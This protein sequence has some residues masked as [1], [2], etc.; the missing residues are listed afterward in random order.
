MKHRWMMAALAALLLCSCSLFKSEVKTEPADDLAVSGMEEFDKKNYKE[1]LAKF[2]KLKDWYP[3]SNYVVMAELK[4]ADAQYQLKEYDQAIAAYRSFAEL[5]PSNEAI[6]YV[7][8][9]I[10]RCYF[11]RIDAVDR[12]Q[13]ATGKA[14]ETFQRLQKLYPDSTYAN[15]AT[16]HINGCLQKLTRSEFLI[17]F[18]YYKRG[19]YKAALNRFKGLIKNYPDVGMHQEALQYIAKCEANL[20]SR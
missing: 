6:P 15:R 4:I 18:Y 8:Y 1:A 5:H 20:V 17:G 13:E 16:E 19:R 3:F 12:D 14:L 10:G 7:Y 11:D 2:Q 9:Q